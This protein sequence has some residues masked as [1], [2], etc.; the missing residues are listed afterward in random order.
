MEAEAAVALLHAAEPVESVLLMRRSER[1]GDPWSG[2]WSLPGGRRDAGDADLLAT[3]LRELEEECGLSLRREDL[4]R[5]LPV[6]KARRR[7]SPFVRVAPFVFRVP[8]QLDATPDR[9]EAV[10]TR[11]LP[12][13]LLRDPAQHRLSPIPGLPRESL[14]PCV[15]L[16]EMPLWG[17]TYRLLTEWL[18]L[19]DG[20]STGA[21]WL[22]GKLSGLT[23][24]SAL[25]R[26]GGPFDEVPPLNM[27]DVQPSGVQ[28]IELD[29]AERWIPFSGVRE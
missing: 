18:G 12:V 5:A 15:P 4:E 8:R 13:D 10:E 19:I 25:H 29:F 9:N 3:A 26:L 1:E 24:E 22:T 11:W 23:S 7:K 16:T 2:H 21:E 17:F 27:V 6:A 20:E 28:V 14:F